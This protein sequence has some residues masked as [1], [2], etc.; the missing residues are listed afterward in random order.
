MRSEQRRKKKRDAMEKW[1]NKIKST[2]KKIL[3]NREREVRWKEGI[4]IQIY[5]L[6]LISSIFFKFYEIFFDLWE[7]IW[8][9]VIRNM[10]KNF[11]KNYFC[12]NNCISLKFP[13]GN[14]WKMFKYS[15]RHS[16]FYLPIEF[17]DLSFKKKSWCLIMS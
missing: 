12:S 3:K 6:T 17:S 1:R 14:I 15:T 9:G 13:G 4:I 16:I 7:K 5:Q 8:T 11:H 2:R 10:E